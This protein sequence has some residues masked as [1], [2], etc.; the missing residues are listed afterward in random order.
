MPVFKLFIILAWALCTA[1]VSPAVLAKTQSYYSLPAKYLPDNPKQHP[2]I[3]LKNRLNGLRQLYYATPQT[4]AVKAFKHDID[5]LL[6]YHTA[7]EDWRCDNGWPAAALA[8]HWLITGNKASGQKACD[9]YL[10]YFSGQSANNQRTDL[11]YAL[12]YDWLYHHPCF[13]GAVKANLRKKL[14]TWSNDTAAADEAGSWIAHDTDRNIAATSGHFLGGLAILGEDKS[15]GLK[16]LKRGWTGWK[17][18]L[19]TLSLPD[20]PV[21]EFFSSSLETGIPLPGWDYGMMS[22]VHMAQNLFYVLDELGIING[23][24]AELKPWWANSLQFFMHSVDPANTH[25]HWL[26]DQQN[27]LVLAEGGGKYIWSYLSMCVFLADHYGYKKQA[28]MGRAFLDQLRKPSYGIS[29]GD[30]MLWFLSSWP[31]KAQRLDYKTQAKRYVVAGIGPK[32]H[33]GMGLFRSD[34]FAK[35]P[36]A[37][38]EKVTWGGFYGIGSYTADHMHNSAGSF[39]LWRNGDYLL[40]EPL[41]YGGNEAAIYPFTL[42]NSL[43]IPNEAVPNNNEAYDNGGPIV[44]FNQQSAYLEL[45]RAD[46]KQKLLYTRLNA[47]HSYNVPENIWAEC[48]GTCR[49]PVK[50][51]TRSFVYDGKT[52]LVFLVDRVDLARTRPV[53]LRFRTQNPTV[54]ST[55]LAN[56]RVSVP[57]EQGTHQTL[58]RVLTP[59]T[60]DA[61][62]IAPEPWANSVDNWQIQTSMIGSQV[63]KSF[64][65][66]LQHR[67]ITLLQP[68]QANSA[69]TALNN[70]AL[71]S[72][73]KALGACASRFCFI[74]H[75]QNAAVYSQL[76]YNTPASTLA[77]ARHLVA[78]LAPGCY[79]ISGSVSGV[80][81]TNQAVNAS[82]HSLLFTVPEGGAQTLSITQTGNTTPSCNN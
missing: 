8:L 21:S 69:T 70:A 44:Y 40:T 17:Y 4:E 31:K 41:N 7:C 54:L 32:Q 15:N 3:Y 30:T 68:T 33:M 60:T 79:S 16:L 75:K 1:L 49:Q 48:S 76:S 34:W 5:K 27:S 77:Q 22:D 29:E 58:I 82:D 67:I 20:F 53:G 47:D 18:G 50:K 65:P 56:D 10:P 39:W 2:R 64:A 28:A 43:S 13:T 57:S 59:Q 9:V 72:S 52:E 36:Y 12:A 63:H 55:Q 42:W 46:D 25:Y 6:S 37:D 11:Y 71:I 38:S 73:A 78:D 23:E 66:A 51:Y 81:A 74:A 45:G 61:W 35:P 24:F 62:T 19:N 14:I 26:G 80:L